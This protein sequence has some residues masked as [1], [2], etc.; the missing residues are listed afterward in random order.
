MTPREFIAKWGAPGGIAGP[1]YALNEEQARKATFWTCVNCWSCPSLAVPRA[2]CL[3][4][5]CAFI[6]GKTG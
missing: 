3:K 4:K 6:G 1:A 5:K 2:T